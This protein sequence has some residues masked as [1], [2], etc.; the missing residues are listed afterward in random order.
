MR[1]I[2]GALSAFL[3]VAPA[4]AAAPAATPCPAKGQ[5]YNFKG[6]ILGTGA[7]ADGRPY[8]AI[9]A[10]V[11]GDEHHQIRVYPLTAVP[12]CTLGK[13]AQASGLYGKSCTDSDAGPACLAEVGLDSPYG[14]ALI[15]Q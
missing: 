10:A 3:I 15:C 1:I 11:C 9:S 5:P 13:R 4:L 14:A 12:A 6:S 8:Y 2:P 7:T